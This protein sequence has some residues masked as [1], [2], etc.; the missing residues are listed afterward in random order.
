[1]NGALIMKSPFYKLLKN[2]LET[3]YF[4]VYTHGSFFTT[5][6]MIINKE[7]PYL[8]HKY[9]FYVIMLLT[10]VTAFL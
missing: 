10:V 1:M 8:K 2:V 9:I 6:I 7:E 4:N 3:F 5:S